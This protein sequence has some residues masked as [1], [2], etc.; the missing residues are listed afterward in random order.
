LLKR[1][2]GALILL[3]L[4]LILGSRGQAAPEELSVSQAVE[5]ALEN[6]LDLLIAR[7]ELDNSRIIY[8]K[9][10][11]DIMRTGSR[12]AELQNDLTLLQAEDRFKQTENQVVRDT[13]DRYF[14]L[15]LGEKEIRSK[16]ETLA[17]E[18][19]RLEEME[20]QVATG[21]RGQLDLM[22]QQGIYNRAA[23]D[24]EESR[25]DL[26]DD[27]EE[28]QYRLGLG[29]MPL[30]DD[31]ALL[32]VQIIEVDREKFIEEGLAASIDIQ[33][34]DKQ[35]L[36]AEMDLK[37]ALEADTPSLDLQE[38]ENSLEI[39]ALE[40]IKAE[41]GGRHRLQRTFNN[42]TRV[43]NNLEL[44]RESLQETEES[45]SIILRQEEAGLITSRD[46]LASRINLMDSERSYLAALNTYLLGA[47][48]IKEARGHSLKEVLHEAI[49][50]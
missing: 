4:F 28:F 18:K 6:N 17:L 14:R 1:K 35:Y 34:R 13:I 22:R 15:I 16:E 31:E 19:R 26:L 40:I 8:Q 32:Q 50:D 41:Q 11:A 27:Q 12:Y 47:L 2:S 9:N 10:K 20:Q 36:L 45:H 21:H 48:D 49:S 3:I 23:F 46:L 5:M 38:K 42:L 7:S 29:N 39:A 25:Q 37:R 43:F 44:A 30:L 33:I 24:L